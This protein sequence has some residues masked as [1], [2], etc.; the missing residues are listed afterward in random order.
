[1]NQPQSV[2]NFKRMALIA[3]GALVGAIFLYITF[4]DVSWIELKKGI[5]AMRPIYFIPGVILLLAVQLVRSL[6]FGVIIS[7]FCSMS[8][9]D[10]WDLLNI[11]AGASILAPARLGEL[12]RPYLLRQ[13]GVSFAEGFG[14]VMVERFFDLLGLLLLLGIVL[15]RT[16]QIPKIYSYVGLALLVGLAAGYVVILLLLA[17]R[18]T[19]EALLAKGASILPVRG[20]DFLQGLFKKLLD[21]FGIMRS[22]RQ[23]LIIF[24]YSVLLWVLFS[25]LTYVFLLAFSID[26]PFLVAVTIQVFICF[27]VALPSAP[28]YIGTFHAA[29]KFALQLFGIQAI[30]A[31]SF[32]TVYHLFS[33]TGCLVLACIS[34][35]TSD[36]TLSAQAFHEPEDST[37][38]LPVAFA[39][40]PSPSRPAES[41]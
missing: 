19:A 24:G 31:V 23:S 41:S 36:F 39:P 18:S 12:A 38:P 9:K 37:T 8:V 10:L 26:P 40:D 33:V 3:V 6:R 17:Y 25:G 34:Y 32:A 1:M 15:W 20:G 7:P 35:W 30:T 13:R 11:W 2:M 21:G 4:R 14:A 22:F 28:G 5:Q 16:P 29:A 27:G